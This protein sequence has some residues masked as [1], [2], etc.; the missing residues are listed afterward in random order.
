MGIY[1]QMPNAERQENFVNVSAANVNTQVILVP[2]TAANKQG[3]LEKLVICNN[4]V[5]A[6]VVKFFDEDIVSTGVSG[7]N[8]PT[9]RGTA[10]APAILP[11]IPLAIG[12]KLVLG[13]NECPNIRIQGGLACQSTVT[14]VHIYAQVVVY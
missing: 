7:T 2:W 11:W 1:E 13:E 14:D 12:E 5:G 9:A 6:A 3:I 4:N 8:K 10:A